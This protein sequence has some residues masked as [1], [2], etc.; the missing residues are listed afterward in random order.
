MFFEN[1]LTIRKSSCGQVVCE[2]LVASDFVR[3][4]E[5]NRGGDCHKVQS[6]M[7]DCHLVADGTVVAESCVL[8]FAGSES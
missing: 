6:Q 7:R 3:L 2:S 1:P 8:E 5:D 4:L